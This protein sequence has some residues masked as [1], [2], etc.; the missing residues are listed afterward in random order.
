MTMP[1][2]AHMLVM[3]VRHVV[4]H[5]TT[6]TR[7]ASLQRRRPD[8]HS[9]V[10]CILNA[11]PAGLANAL[12]RIQNVD[13]AI[14]G[15][16]LL[17][18]ALV[19]RRVGDDEAGLEGRLACIQTLL[20]HG[21]NPNL[22][23]NNV[24]PFAVAL[25]RGIGPALRLLIKAGA[26]WTPIR[27]DGRLFS[28]SEDIEWQTLDELRIIST[29]ISSEVAEVLSDYICAGCGRQLATRKCAQCLRVRYCCRDCQKAHWPEHRGECRAEA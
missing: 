3:Y 22:T 16:T 25:S 15:G 17:Q 9:A 8:W 6:I 4:F 18:I 7:D 10:Q 23:H 1:P 19:G 24:T 28:L 11:D 5:A 13:A 29:Q 27:I 20:D 14:N 21:A 2:G 26:T 12:R